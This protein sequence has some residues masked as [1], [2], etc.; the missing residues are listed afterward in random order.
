MTMHDVLLSNIPKS[1]P[2]KYRARVQYWDDERECGNSLIVSLEDG[3]KFINT[4]C[5]TSGFDTVKEAIEGLRDTI[6]CPCDDCL[7]TLVKRLILS[8]K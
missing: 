7:N 3:W 6:P 5:H 8:S 2:N 4:D 1:V